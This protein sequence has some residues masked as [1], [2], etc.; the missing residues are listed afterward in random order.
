MNASIQR[1]KD[2][3]RELI[4]A[5]K[6]RDRT[7]QRISTGAWILTFV[8]LLFTAVGVGFNVWW[9]AA[10]FLRGQVGMDVIFRE[11]MP[12]VWIV[13][14]ISLL[15]AVLSTAGVLLR[16]RAASLDEIRL[17]LAAVE[18]MLTDQTHGGEDVRE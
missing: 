14:A 5:E 6:G 17:R 13:G 12:F 11:A 10:A 18:H 15:V 2:Q 7:L 16:F 4:E 3:I 9:A 8:A 1:Q